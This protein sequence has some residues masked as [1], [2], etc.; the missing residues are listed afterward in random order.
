MNCS[1]T[2]PTIET[3]SNLDRLY[4]LSKQIEIVF[5]KMKIAID[6]SAAS[7][8]PYFLD[9][10]VYEQL[11]YLSRLDAYAHTLQGALEEGCEKSEEILIWY[12]IR[13]LGVRPPSEL[14]SIIAPDEFVEI[15]D[16]NGIQVF[17][18]FQACRLLSYS[19]HQ[20]LL[21]S[22]ERLYERPESAR[23]QIAHEFARVFREGNLIPSPAI[24]IHLGQEIESERRRRFQVEMKYFSP[25]YSHKGRSVQYMLGGSTVTLVD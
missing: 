17:R 21:K 6:T 16:V 15:Y 18:N 22:W 2:H 5:S 14:F 9:L 25:L 23:S 8:L 10:P 20:L 13:R 24:D 1:L 19:L 12:A 4:T 3:T 11:T 7:I